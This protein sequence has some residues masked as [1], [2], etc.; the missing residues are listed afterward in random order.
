M[1]DQ[2]LQ[3]MLWQLGQKVDDLE[4]QLRRL[5][6][7]VKNIDGNVVYTANAVRE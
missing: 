1:T 2:Q 3:G 5:E 4:S 7:I 6:R